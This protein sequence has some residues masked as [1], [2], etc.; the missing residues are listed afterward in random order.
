[1]DRGTWWATVHGVA[2][3]WTELKWPSMYASMPFLWAWGLIFLFV[4]ELNESI[5]NKKS[6]FPQR[7]STLT[8]VFSYKDHFSANAQ[9][10]SN[11]FRGG[12]LT[13][14]NWLIWKDPDAGKDWRQEEKGTTEDEMIEWHHRLNEFE[15]WVWVISGCWW[16]IGRP[17]MVQ[18]MGSQRIGHDWATELN[19]T[20]LNPL[21]VFADKVLW[22]QPHP[23]VYGL[24]LLSCYKSCLGSCHRDWGAHKAGYL[25]LVLSR[26]T[27][28][29]QVLKQPLNLFVLFWAILYYMG[30]LSSQI[31]DGTLCFLKWKHRIL[32]TESP[33]SSTS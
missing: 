26:K 19:W 28:P 3:C 5:L 29:I 10:C 9:S 24:W 31:K 16:W 2:K 23:F 22:K 1:M 18:S 12:T 7:L 20:E 13:I 6:S 14:C 8:V 27:L 25:Y 32:T 15:Y 17:G 21:S 33:G 11:N 4:G 30:D